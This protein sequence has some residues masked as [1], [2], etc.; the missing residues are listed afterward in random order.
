LTQ[1][2]NLEIAVVDTE[3]QRKEILKNFRQAEII[4]E[5]DTYKLLAKVKEYKYII[6]EQNKGI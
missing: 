2:K 3:K 6:H 5:K 1:I 4:N